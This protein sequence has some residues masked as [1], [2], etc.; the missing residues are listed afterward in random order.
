MDD[1]KWRYKRDAPPSP[2]TIILVGEGT[3]NT[4]GGFLTVN[5]SLWHAGNAQRPWVMAPGYRHGGRD[6]RPIPGNTIGRVMVGD[7]ANM[8]Y[9]DGHARGHQVEELSHTTTPN[10]FKFW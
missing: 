5:E 1:E 4:T 10:L 9:G 6:T 2:S 8:V 7:V 3:E